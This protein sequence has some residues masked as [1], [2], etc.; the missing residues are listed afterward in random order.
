LNAK[1][2]DDVQTENVNETTRAE[3]PAKTGPV[4]TCVGCGQHDAPEAFVRVVL[5][6]RVGQ[7][8][9]TLAVDMAGGTIGR[10]A[11]VHARPICLEKAA[12]GGFG[13]SFKCKVDP[14]AASAK[15]IASQIVE[16]CDRRIAGLLMGA[17]RAN[18][19]AVGADAVCDALAKGANCIVVANDAGSVI[20]K[21][22]IAYAV[23]D[24][25]A[26]AWKNKAALGALFGRDE[27]AVCA[28]S[29]ESV[30]EQLLRARR[31][32]DAVVGIVMSRSDACRSREVR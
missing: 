21:G 22:P 26:V 29:H 2:R 24:G 9:A 5:G 18:Y 27:V 10:G 14:S 11:H 19:V 25:R 32:A 17:R 15:E 31:M 13:R 3:R 12:K 1:K 28:V 8:P 20:E 6:P 7:E 23:T 4:R 30:A 16:G